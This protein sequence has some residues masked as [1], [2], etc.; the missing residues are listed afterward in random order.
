MESE[1]SA[2]LDRSFLLAAIE[3]LACQRQT[4]S[5][6]GQYPVKV[7]ARTLRDHIAGALDPSG[8]WRVGGSREY[9]RAR[10]GAS[11]HLVG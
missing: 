2:P 6:P 3:I 7:S 4:P 1:A 5:G 9:L 8:A 11:S 10:Y